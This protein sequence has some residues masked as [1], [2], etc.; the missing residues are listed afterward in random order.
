MDFHIALFDNHER[1][2]DLVAA[3]L[4]RNGFK[5]QNVSSGE[6]LRRLLRDVRFDLLMIDVDHPE[7]DALE[8][9]RQT[10][11]EHNIPI[12]LT[13]AGRTDVSDKVVG[14][15]LG[16]DDY[17]V[18]PF[19]LDELL[20]RVAISLRRSNDPGGKGMSRTLCFQGWCLNYRFRTLRDP[21][22]LLV[23][24][25]DNELSILLAFLKAPGRTLPRL[26]LLQS[27]RGVSDDSSPRMVDNIVFKLRKKIE[28][29]PKKPSMIG[30]V[31]G[32]GYIFSSDV[33]EQYSVN[34][35][36]DVRG[37]TV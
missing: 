34:R 18:K 9:L 4:T 2:R 13:T 5:I 7:E 8:I 22:G 16:A 26:H 28:I 33:S 3:C 14:L 21:N 1:D 32:E 30:T 23:V 27:I 31:R 19:C 37:R 29:N 10:V 11:S 20:A 35:F 25:T 12:I 15:E 6:C 24:L 36:G 17:I